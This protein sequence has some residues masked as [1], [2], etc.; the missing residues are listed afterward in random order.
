MSSTGASA[1]RRCGRAEVT[2]DLAA[3]RR[4]TYPRPGALPEVESAPLDEDLGRRDFTINAM[5]LCLTGEGFGRLHDPA[6][7]RA[8]LE[9]GLV[10]VLHERSFEDDPTRLL[11]ALRYE[12][13]LGLAMDPDTERLARAAAEAGA[14]DTVSGPRVADELLDLLAEPEA[15]AA[16]ERLRALGLDRALHPALDAD[17]VLV[18]SAALGSAE[19]GADRSLAALAALCSADPDAL[20]GWLDRLQLNAAARDAVAR[21]ARAAPGIAESCAATRGRQQVYSLL[22]DEPPETLALALA[23]GAPPGPILQFVGDLRHVRLEISGDDLLAA[24][25]A[26]VAGNG[27]GAR[28]D[29][30]AQARRRARGPRRG[31]EGGAGAGEGRGMIRMELPGAEVV[32]STRQGGVSEGP[33]ESLNLGILT[34]D[35]PELVRENRG[36]LAEAA[37]VDPGRVAMGWQVHGVDLLE[38]PEP[39]ERGGFAAPGAELP[40]VDGHITSQ[41]GLGLLVLVADCLP[42]AL[43]GGGQVAMLHCGWRG[44][45]EGII[46]RALDALRRAAGGRDRTRHR[47][48]LLRGG[49]GGARR[50]RGARGRAPGPDARPA[51]RGPAQARGGGRRPDRGGGPLHQ[52]PWGP[53]LLAPARR[54]SHRTAGRPRMDPGRVAD[55]LARVRERIAAAGREPSE[56]EICAA[57]K[58]VPSEDLPALAEGGIKLVGENRA[59]DLLAKQADHGGLFEWDFIG[60]LQSRKVR[61]VAPHV[62][63]IHSV[64]SESVLR[65]LER[66]PA[67]EVLVQVNVAGEEGKAG[68]GPEELA[69]FIERCPV[70]VRG[71]M[72]MPPFVE[73]GED[74]RRWFA[75]LAEL[76]AEHDLPRLSMGTTQDYE[77][78]VQEGATVVRLGMALYG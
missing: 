57:I 15:P 22:K 26:R 71:L 51:R 60:S 64:A 55:N 74:N 28:G 12:A 17:P 34:D 70:P 7:G 69:G 19:T 65:Q 48:L 9:A 14:L 13:R 50:L 20:A 38:W 47:P 27:P 5:A 23:L 3:T 44:L 35:A 25:V 42:V 46:E 45:A 16:V 78:A 2:F 11:R 43:A 18:A 33:Y 40:R 68:I 66:H 10:R 8:D 6:G 39:P 1:P 63:L 75:R 32:F 73:R 54:G 24:G 77:V 30:A 36:L 72:T 31:A 52:L 29:A 49:G 61:D 53:V 76:A 4:E 56:V 67:P 37:G 59:Q 21:A 41:A 62:R 58:Y